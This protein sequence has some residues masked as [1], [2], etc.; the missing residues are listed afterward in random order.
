MA[1]ATLMIDMGFLFVL[2][3][4]AGFAA[5]PAAALAIL[6]VFIIRY[7]IARSWVWSKNSFKKL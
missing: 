5:V 4:Y 1:L 2:V 7:A 6:I 3:E